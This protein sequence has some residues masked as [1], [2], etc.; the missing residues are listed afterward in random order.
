[1]GC[2]LL[3]G[4]CAGIPAHRERQISAQ[5]SQWDAATRTRLLDQRIELGD[6]RA[7][8]YVALGP[9]L[10][11]P[12]LT[13][14]HPPREHWEFLAYETEPA[15][16]S[17]T[18]GTA[19]PLESSPVQPEIR[20]QTTNNLVFPDLS[21]PPAR[22]LVVEFGPDDRVVEWRLYPDAQGRVVNPGFV[23]ISMP[24]SPRGKTA[25]AAAPGN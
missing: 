24:R 22:L 12:T 18:P 19:V 11:A 20:A 7:M 6:T 17:G 16:P 21:G 5:S 25:S 23:V 10:Y 9:P 8:A 3:V 13:D 15:F 2:S 1:M 14:D 4:A